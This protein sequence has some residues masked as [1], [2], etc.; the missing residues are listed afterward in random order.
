MEE[1]LVSF[2][3]AKLAKERGFNIQ[4]KYFFNTVGT[5]FGDGYDLYS[6]KTRTGHSEIF[7]VPTQF[8]LQKW[9][10]EKYNIDIIIK[11][12][13][14]DKVGSKTYASDVIIFG[15]TTYI[16]CKR[17]DFYEEALEEGLKQAL[18]LIK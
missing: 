10:R 9:L 1:P 6:Y 5:L 13:T 2:E 12:W 11:P 15:T 16:K 8:L 7:L 18:L 3:V 17:C 4:S 14:G